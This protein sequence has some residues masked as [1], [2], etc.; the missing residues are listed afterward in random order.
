MFI[1]GG[2]KITS[3]TSVIFPSSF[4]HEPRF[5]IITFTN[6]TSILGSPLLSLVKERRSREIKV[7]GVVESFETSPGWEL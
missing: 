1:K 4:S 6:R 7:S 2:K 3:K 5:L